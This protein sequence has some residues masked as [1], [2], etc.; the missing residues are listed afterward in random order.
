M[1]EGRIVAVR[2]MPAGAPPAK[3]GCLRSRL[4][5]PIVPAMPVNLWMSWEG[6]VD[7]V[8]ATQPGLAMPNF[9]LHVARVVHTPVGSAPAGMV[10]WQ[11]DPKGPPAVIGFLS[12]DPKLAAWFGPNIFAGTPFEK[13]PALT[14]AITT[15]VA[16]ER[17]SSRVEVA[18]HVFEVAMTGVGPHELIHRAAGSPMP[19]AQQ[20]LEAKAARA[21][22]KVNGKPVAI[23]VPPLSI[24]GGPGAVVSVC[25]VY[26][27]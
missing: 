9:L 20:G 11:P 4:L 7:V 1:A 13:A 6:G 12:S 8:G 22:L 21:E 24:G 16:G 27:R 2:I 25:G 14:A 23:T 10:L 15:T 5:M 19:F 18:G 3:S 17:A 26:A